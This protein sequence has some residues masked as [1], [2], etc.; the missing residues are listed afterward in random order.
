MTNTSN[1]TFLTIFYE[2]SKRL[3]ISEEKLIYVG[4]HPVNDID[5]A[6]RA[7]YK[8]VWVKTNGTWVEGCIKPSAEIITVDELPSLLD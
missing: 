3:K 5:A 4:D 6:S 8:T 7:G 1:L 2:M